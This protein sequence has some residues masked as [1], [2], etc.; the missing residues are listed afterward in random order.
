M[1]SSLS[2]QI[3]AEFARLSPEEQ[4]SL[5]ERLVGEFRVGGW[6]Q[7]GLPQHPLAGLESNPELQRQLRNVRPDSSAAHG[8]LLN[9]GY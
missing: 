4:L 3:V 1:A 5:L 2:N 9:E 6:G 7:R 8:D